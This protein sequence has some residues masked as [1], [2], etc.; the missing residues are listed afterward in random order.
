MVLEGFLMRKILVLKL[1]LSYS[2][3]SL[4]SRLITSWSKKLI[5]YIWSQRG[6]LC[7]CQ[8]ASVMSDS[9][10]L[11]TVAHQVQFKGIFSKDTGVGH[12]V[13]F[14]GIFP[15]QGSNTHL[16]L[17]HWQVGWWFLFVCF[18]PLA[19][20]WKPFCATKKEK[21]CLISGTKIYAGFSFPQSLLPV[22]Q[23]ALRICGAKDWNLT[24][25]TQPQYELQV[26]IR[27]S[28]AKNL[29]ICIDPDNHVVLC[30]YKHSA[31][32]LQYASPIVFLNI[33]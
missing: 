33:A 21:I 30:F 25:G 26:L 11:W 24:S 7:L 1:K 10:T 22:F 23:S 4:H 12:H 32:E 29:V 3:M 31:S 6:C 28:H 27:D 14:Q 19:P 16:C 8:A 17:L 5:T 2:S 15:A 13:L 20:P 9:A 18:L